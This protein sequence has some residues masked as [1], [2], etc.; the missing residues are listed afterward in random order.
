MNRHHA[1]LNNNWEVVRIFLTK[2]LKKRKLSM[3]FDN[4]VIQ[5]KVCS[6]FRQKNVAKLT[7]SRA[8]FFAGPGELLTLLISVLETVMLLYKRKKTHLCIYLAKLF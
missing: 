7:E 3:L 5:L 4:R 2:L 6:E 1:E 8:Y